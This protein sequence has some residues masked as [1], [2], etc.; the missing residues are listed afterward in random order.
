MSN[1]EIVEIL[2]QIVDEDLKTKLLIMHDALRPQMELMPAAVSH[3]HFWT[4]GILQHISEVMTIVQ[5]LYR[6][7]ERIRGTPTTFTMDDAI[8]VAYIHDLDKLERYERNTT[9]W[10]TK[11]VAYPFKAKEDLLTCESTG[12]IAT[13]CAQYRIELSREHL[14]SLAFH[15]GGFSEYMSSVY[16]KYQPEMSPLATLLHCADLMSGFILGRKEPT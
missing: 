3:H 6:I 16:V 12:L 15:H 10:K 8:L 14:H 7:M 13:K 5:V 4:G 1:S 11:G 9:N 2:N